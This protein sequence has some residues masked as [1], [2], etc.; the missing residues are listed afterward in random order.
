MHE[1]YLLAAFA[2]IQDQIQRQDCPP[3]G[4]EK[5]SADDILRVREA[6]SAVRQDRDS[7]SSS[8]IAAIALMTD[9]I[10]VIMREYDFSYADL[11]LFLTRNDFPITERKLRKRIAMREDAK[12]EVSVAK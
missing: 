7:R 8:I 5:Y 11:A 2:P 4:R 10:E 3:M 6:F 9:A 1:R 12:D